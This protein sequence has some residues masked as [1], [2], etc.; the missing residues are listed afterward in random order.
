MNRKIMG[1]VPISSE[2]QKK[3]KEMQ[4]EP[5][6]CYKAGRRAPSAEFDGDTVKGCGEPADDIVDEVIVEPEGK[7]PGEV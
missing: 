7:F 2:N 6:V 5:P 1:S 4:T 3:C